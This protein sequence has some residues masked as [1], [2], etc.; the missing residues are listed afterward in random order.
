[1]RM[2]KGMKDRNAPKDISMSTIVLENKR[3][4]L[5]LEPQI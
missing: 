1:M 4:Y 2:E 3:I 5:F